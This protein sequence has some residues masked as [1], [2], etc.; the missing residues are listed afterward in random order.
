M[1][2]AII[3]N[4]GALDRFTADPHALLAGS[5]VEQSHP[6]IEFNELAAA[7]LKHGNPELNALFSDDAEYVCCAS[8]P[9]AVRAMLDFCGIQFRERAVIWIAV[10]YDTAALKNAH[11]TPWYPVIDRER[12]TG[13]G[14]CHDYCLF[15]TYRRD[16]SLDPAHRIQVAH[17]LNC[18][19]GCPACARLCVRGAVIFP[20]NPE[21]GINGELE[22]PASSAESD[23]LKAFEA[24]PMK[25]LA[26]RRKKRQLIAE[27]HLVDVQRDGDARDDSI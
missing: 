8:R 19:V 4:M 16:N 21:P 9:R 12:C 11:G 24:D 18:K 26:E 3:F 6:V 13:C 7:A 5:G 25:V 20:F 1:K 10:A 22:T 2:K 23:L 27:Q 14:I 17:P 15:G